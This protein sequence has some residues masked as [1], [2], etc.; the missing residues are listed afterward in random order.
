[1]SALEL[2]AEASFHVKP[3]QQTQIKGRVEGRG[4]L[5]WHQLLFNCF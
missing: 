5:K 2:R 3:S 1:M 4:A